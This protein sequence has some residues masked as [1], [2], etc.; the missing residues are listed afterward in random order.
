L[1]SFPQGFFVITNL[2]KGDDVF[3]NN[4]KKKNKNN[5]DNNTNN[6]NNSDSDNDNGITY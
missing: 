1:T 4:K 2:V 6:E 5:V 3:N